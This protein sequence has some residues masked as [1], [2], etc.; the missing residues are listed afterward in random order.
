MAVDLARVIPPLVR[1]KVDFILIGGMAGI[2]HGS[3]RMTF[4]VDLV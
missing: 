1:E 4:Y 2:L 3:A